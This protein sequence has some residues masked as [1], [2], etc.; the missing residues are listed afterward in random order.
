MVAV[1][2]VGEPGSDVKPPGGPGS[3]VVVNCSSAA[4]TVDGPARPES[5]RDSSGL[6]ESEGVEQCE[7]HLKCWD[8]RKA[9]CAGS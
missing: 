3:A 2:A 6:K 1:L 7:E 8:W 9:H 4:G 5:E